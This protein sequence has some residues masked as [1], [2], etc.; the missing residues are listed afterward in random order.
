MSFFL[1]IDTSNYTTSTALYDDETGKMLQQKKLL[2]V[3]EGRLGLRQSDA[4]F[5]HTQ[6]LH[7]LFSALVND[8]DISSV[9]AVG[10]SSRPR[11]SEGSYMP[12]F[13]VGVNAAEIISS[14]L[15][16]P[17]YSFSHQEGHISA[18]V[19]SSEREDLFNKSFLAFHVSGGTTEAVAVCGKGDGFQ[20]NTAAKSLDLHA[21]QAIDRVGLMLGLKFPCGAELEKLALKNNEKISARPAVRGF[22]CCLSGVENICRKL[23]DQNKPAEYV[24]AYCINYIEQSISLMTERLLEHYGNLPVLY[25]GGVMSDSIIKNSL[26][27]KYNAIFA[28]PQYSADNAAGI[29]YLAYRKFKNVHT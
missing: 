4:V 2:P 16:I 5:L 21:G 14:A 25:A 22:D 20:L 26:K 18:A 6:Q 13:T 7:T 19:F 15:R 28:E 3:K 11:P 17:M 27:E 1:G 12:C 29:A 10:A 9:R 23:L 24:A 8:I